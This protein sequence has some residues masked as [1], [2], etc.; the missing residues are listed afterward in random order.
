MT[1]E[2]AED[3]NNF[4][5]KKRPTKQ[6]LSSQR[7][8]PS[9]E[10]HEPKGLC[11]SDSRRDPSPQAQSILIPPART[12]STS[13]HVRFQS[14]IRQQ[15]VEDTEILLH[16]LLM[17]P[18]GKDLNCAPMQPNVYLNCKLLGSDE[19][20]RSAVSWG[21]K[22]PT[23]SFTQVSKPWRIEERALPLPVVGTE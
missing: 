17:V 7:P 16:M 1:F 4:S 19:T 6:I 2:L 8:L 15:E 10:D 14:S 11:V 21:Q 9:E 23:F 20:A 5:S 3:K 12:R 22:H 13:P 18:D